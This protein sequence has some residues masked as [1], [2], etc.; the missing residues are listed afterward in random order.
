MV[1][2]DR[3]KLLAESKQEA[4]RQLHEELTQIPKKSKIKIRDW[5]DDLLDWLEKWIH[6]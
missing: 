4:E 3:E 2:I 6:E 1:E 5:K